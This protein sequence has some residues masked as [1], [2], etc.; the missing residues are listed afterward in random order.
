VTAPALAWQERRALLLGLTAAAGW[1]DALAWLTL[2]KI[3]LS[4]MSGNLLFVGLGLGTG[5]DGQTGRAAVVLAAFLVGTTVGARLTGSRLAAGRLQAPMERTIALE[6]ILLAVFALVWLVAGTPGVGSAEAFVLLVVA[7][8][9]M[10]LQAAVSLAFH[11]PNV[12]TVAM[13]ATLAQLGALLGWR[14]REGPAVML[15]SVEVSL[16]VPLCVAYL[17][18]AIAVAAGPNGAAMAFGPVVL[19][20]AGVALDAGRERRSDDS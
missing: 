8:T 10:G 6:G 7:A 16:L 5:L 18:S 13:T 1:L 2:G 11:L 19:L 3:F 4:F 12:A 17:L 9:A 14:W 15:G 20:A